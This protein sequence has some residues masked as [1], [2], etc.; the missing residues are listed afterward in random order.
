[1]T[2]QATYDDVKFPGLGLME[3][4]MKLHVQDFDSMQIQA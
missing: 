2:E 1:M 4:F 3:K